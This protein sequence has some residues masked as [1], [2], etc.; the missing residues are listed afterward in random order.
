[1]EHG[2]WSMEHGAWGMGHGAW[3]IGQRPWPIA[4]VHGHTV[5]LLA[6]PKPQI[7][8]AGAPTN[9]SHIIFNVVSG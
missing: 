9:T 7:V 5:L 2:A 8:G 4:S 1:M 3:S 6:F